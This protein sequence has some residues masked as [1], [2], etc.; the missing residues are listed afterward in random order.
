M[1]NKEQAKIKSAWLHG[2]L[3]KEF[4]DQNIRFSCRASHED[5]HDFCVIVQPD[6][7]AADVVKLT[8]DVTRKIKELE[9]HAN[10]EIMVFL[11]CTF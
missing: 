9:S 5:G 11:P 1:I 2:E 6:D 8:A 4:K 7:A 3:T 10:P